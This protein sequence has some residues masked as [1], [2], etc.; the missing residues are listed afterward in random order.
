MNL[1]IDVRSAALGGLVAMTL[2]SLAAFAPQ[3]SVSPPAAHITPTTASS[4]YPAA[5]ELV[6]L[7]ASSP[8]FG[9]P[10]V[11]STAFLVPAGKILVVSAIGSTI[12]GGNFVRLS[13]DGV[14]RQVGRGT[15]SL[16]VGWKVREGRTLQ[17][18]A[19]PGGATTF[20]PGEYHWLTGYLADA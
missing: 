14:T 2:T 11:A 15:T 18:E 13:L 8:G 4:T 17:L 5:S 9:Q 6:Y 16:G 1:T 7:D 19:V 10:G 3:A 12:D 20:P